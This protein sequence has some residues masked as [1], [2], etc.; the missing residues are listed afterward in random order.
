MLALEGPQL[1][2]VPAELG[3]RLRSDDD[4]P[5]AASNRLATFYRKGFVEPMER[6]VKPET[7]VR[8]A[9]AIMAA[10]HEG[11]REVSSRAG[12]DR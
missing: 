1:E 8:R 5:D 2:T 12:S 6:A 7:R 10:L 11:R 4:G 9:E 3:E